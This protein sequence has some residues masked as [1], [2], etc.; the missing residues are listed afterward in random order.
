MTGEQYMTQQGIPH[1][2]P[3]DLWQNIVALLSISLGFLALTYIQLR[4]IE[5]YKWFA[6][7]QKYMF[8]ERVI[9]NISTR[10]FSIEMYDHTS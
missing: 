10:L 6:E 8:P 4:R 7:S 5:K 2:T 1:G 9:L 3:W